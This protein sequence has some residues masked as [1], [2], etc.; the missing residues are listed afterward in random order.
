MCW[1]GKGAEAVLFMYIYIYMQYMVEEGLG[2]EDE[3]SG[4]WVYKKEVVVGGR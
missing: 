3:C 4:V 2:R 1:L